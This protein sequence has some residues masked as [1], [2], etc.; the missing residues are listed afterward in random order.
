MLTAAG[1]LCVTGGS[2]IFQFLLTACLATSPLSAQ[3]D[4]FVG[5]WKLIKLT[6]QMKVT[7]VG[8]DTPQRLTHA[9]HPTAG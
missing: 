3:A 7:K 5:Q 9:G 4:P 6:D 8:A 1:S 2:R